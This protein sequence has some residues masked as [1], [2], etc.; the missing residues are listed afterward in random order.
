[1][2]S[3]Y[4]SPW[5]GAWY[6]GA[7]NRRARRQLQ[8]EGLNRNQLKEE[9]LNA[10]VEMDIKRLVQT[11]GAGRLAV[12]IMGSSD[13]PIWTCNSATVTAGD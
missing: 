1:M 8:I 3:A 4:V 5:I 9:Q 7:F 6:P 10:S 11:I 2:N 13:E 12:R